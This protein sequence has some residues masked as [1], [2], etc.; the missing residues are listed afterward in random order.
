MALEESC[1][2]Q[3]A[4]TSEVQHKKPREGEYTEAEYTQARPR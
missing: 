4:H 1:Q 2:D 3:G